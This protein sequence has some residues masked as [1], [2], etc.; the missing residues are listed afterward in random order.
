VKRLRLSLSLDDD[1]VLEYSDGQDCVVGTD[2]D[3]VYMKGNPTTN[4]N[5]VCG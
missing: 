4:F 5:T 1:F 2:I 3:V